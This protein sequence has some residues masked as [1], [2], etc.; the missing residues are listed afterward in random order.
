MCWKLMMVFGGT[1]RCSA[2]AVRNFPLTL[3]HFAMTQYDKSLEKATTAADATVSAA[4]LVV[5]RGTKKSVTNQAFARAEDAAKCKL[6]LE[7]TEFGCD[8]AIKERQEK[9]L[10][11]LEH[12]TTLVDTTLAASEGGGPAPQV[13]ARSLSDIS[14]GCWVRQCLVVGRTASLIALC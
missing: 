2:K 8:D 4:A 6:G 11:R 7:P 5:D 3:E 14:G 1:T 12:L 9:V 10:S 13:G